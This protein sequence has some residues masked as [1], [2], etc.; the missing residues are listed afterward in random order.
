VNLIG[1]LCSDGRFFYTVNVG[2]TNSLTFGFFLAKLCDHLDSV[3][4]KWRETTVL[5]LD[6]ANH[7]KSVVSRE[8]MASLHL[9]VLFLG[10]YHFGMQPIEM[11]FNFIKGHDLNPLRT[12]LTTW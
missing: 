8:L 3:N 7:H 12:K 6:N 4:N 9:P 2:K 1:A 5:M 10:P 11:V